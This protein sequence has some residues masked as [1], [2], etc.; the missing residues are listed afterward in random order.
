VKRILFLI[1]V[2]LVFSLSCKKENE[3]S[4]NSQ[5]NG[6]VK[7]NI[8]VVVTAMHHSWSV[9]NIRVF[10]KK[11]VTSWPGRDTTL[12]TWKATTDASGSVTFRDLFKGNYYIYATGYDINFGANVIGYMPINLNDTTA[13]GNEAY[14]TLMVSE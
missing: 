9:S 14:Y 5:G 11:D 13:A 12:Y 2:A 3:T 7:G 10:M 1:L 6:V 4:T 8:A